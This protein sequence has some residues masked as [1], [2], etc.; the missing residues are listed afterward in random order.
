MVPW[1]GSWPT[2]MTE[3]YTGTSSL[4]AQRSTYKCMK[5]SHGY[6]NQ[7]NQ[8]RQVF[9]LTFVVW[10]IRWENGGEGSCWWGLK[11]QQG[12]WCCLKGI[13]GFINRIPP[14]SN[15]RKRVPEYKRFCIARRCRVRLS[16]WTFISIFEWN[17]MNLIFGGNYG[18]CHPSHLTPVFSPLLQ[19]IVTS[20]SLRDMKCE[21]SY[22]NEGGGVTLVGE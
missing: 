19:A 13:S 18:I 7:T 17:F 3:V 2:S 21:C 1:S 10:R 14:H 9:F 16:C 20:G 11:R 4:H 8:T 22:Q 15:P 6:V 5:T 12:V